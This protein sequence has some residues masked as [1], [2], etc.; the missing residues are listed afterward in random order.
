MFSSMAFCRVVV[1]SGRRRLLLAAGGLGGLVKVMQRGLRVWNI[2]VEGRSSVGG[3]RSVLM[4]SLIVVEI[5][6]GFDN[7]RMAVL[8]EETGD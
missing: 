5:E 4:L 6:G 2:L 1:S 3:G 7:W 8:Y